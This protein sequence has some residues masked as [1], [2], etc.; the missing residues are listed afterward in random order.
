MIVSLGPVTVPSAQTSFTLSLQPTI[1]T[2]TP[3]PIAAT[4]QVLTITPATIGTQT[5]AAAQPTTPSDSTVTSSTT[6][7]FLPDVSITEIAS[8]MVKPVTIAHVY[9]V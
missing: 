3:T 7:S 4:S 6:I 1:L 5:T 8:L 9:N 2:G